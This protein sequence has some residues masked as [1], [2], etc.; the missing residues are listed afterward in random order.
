MIRALIIATCIVAAAA[1]AHA[2]T[3]R[4]AVIVGNNEGNATTS[5]LHFA[6]TDA[7]KLAQVLGELGGVAPADLFMLRGQS[8]AALT[9]T[10]ERVRRLIAGLRLNPANRVVVLFY[11][12]GHSDGESL[13][14]GRDR[15]TFSELRRWLAALGADVRVVLVDS[16]KSGALLAAKGGRPAAGFQ[17]RMTDELASSGEALLTSSAADEAS[18]ESREIAG[19]FFTHHLISGLRGAADTSGDGLVTLAEAYQ[20]AYAH[21][22]KTT[23]ETVVGMQHPAY[24][25]R[26][27]GQGELVLSE[28][29]KRTATLQLPSGFERIV[30]I[31][32]AR[33]Q[34]AAEVTSDTH[35]R[36][37]VQPGRYAIHARRAGKLYA[38]RVTVAVGGERVVR[39][40]ELTVATV[41]STAS[42]GAFLDE[43]PWQ[44]VV[45]G[46]V[47]TGVAQNLGDLISGRIELVAPAAWS[48]SV[49]VGSRNTTTFRETTTRVLAGYRLGMTADAW[50]L[51]IGLELGGGLIVQSRLHPANYSGVVAAGGLA[52]GALHLTPR[53]AA[54]L[55]VA[56][57]AE[58]LKRDGATALLA[59]PAGWLGILVQL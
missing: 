58:M 18:L 50:S 37:A 34:V 36:L 26:L 12:S 17:I 14:L 42:K 38:A 23:G 31:D 16:C 22:L 30:V 57:S 13:E 47:R 40:E 55:E 15:L 54:V 2:S 56:L 21:T 20:Y 1:T 7:T 43:P 6:E 28:L 3:R 9:S 29:A 53:L 48:L 52:G 10:F 33:D 32:L 35:V 46:G 45:A 39:D 4:I 44:V 41:A 19:S 8:L 51:W 25:Y 24:D 49:D 27:S 11:F 5:P 59:V